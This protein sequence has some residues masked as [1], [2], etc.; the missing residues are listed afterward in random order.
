MSDFEE[1]V[2]RQFDKS[3]QDYTCQIY[4]KNIA[5]KVLQ[6]YDSGAQFLRSFGKTPV[7]YLDFQK[8]LRTLE[9]EY[10]IDD[11]SELLFEWM[12]RESTGMGET[13][14]L[15]FYQHLKSLL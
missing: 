11:V 13:E 9:I 1:T 15:R 4:M 14:L 2:P 6:R 10:S 7:S 3:E 8:Y 12:P 5:D